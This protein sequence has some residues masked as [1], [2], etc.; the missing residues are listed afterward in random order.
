[1]VPGLGENLRFLWWYKMG[2]DIAET[3]H[4]QQWQEAVKVSESFCVFIR[5]VSLL[6]ITSL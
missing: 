3:S 1:M 4:Y 5:V 6:L 2:A